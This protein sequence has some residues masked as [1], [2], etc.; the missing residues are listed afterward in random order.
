MKYKH[1]LNVAFSAAREAGAIILSFFKKNF[2]VTAKSSTEYVT[3]ADLAADARIKAMI[4]HYFPDDAWLSEE[5]IDSRQRLSNSRVWIVDPLDGTH[6]FMEGSPDFT[7]CIALIENGEPQVGVVLRPIDNE[8]YF[9]VRGEG[10]FLNHDRIYCTTEPLLQEAVIVTSDEEPVPSKILAINQQVK[11]V[12]RFG[13]T[14]YKIIRVAAG[15][16]ELYISAELKKEWDICAADL[17]VS[18]AGGRLTDWAGN[19]AKYNQPAPDIE[20]G[21]IATN[22]PLHAKI[23]AQLQL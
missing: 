6:E 3:S 17:I 20:F 7:I 18:E 8:L 5:T 1:E 4:L 21:M 10:A 13:S 12:D 2:E 11:R 14:A 16:A 23:V 9:A 19:P 15:Q 22:Y